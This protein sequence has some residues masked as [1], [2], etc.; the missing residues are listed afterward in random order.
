MIYE[1]KLDLVDVRRSI[2][3]NQAANLHTNSD[4]TCLKL[5]GERKSQHKG[6]NN[7]LREQLS[8]YKCMVSD[9][10]AR[11]KDQENEKRSLNTVIKILQD[12]QD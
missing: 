10:N 5:S 11:V 9:L 7:A 3:E 6:Q 4:R 1:S 2:I 12:V 8:T